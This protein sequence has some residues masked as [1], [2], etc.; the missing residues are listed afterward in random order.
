MTFENKNLEM[1]TGMFAFLNCWLNHKE[2]KY[3]K[4]VWSY[5]SLDGSDQI[6]LKNDNVPVFGSCVH[7]YTRCLTKEIVK[8]SPMTADK[9]YLLMSS[10]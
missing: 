9:L 8:K 7:A 5:I 2:S 6:A 10:S 1:F 3:T 4:V